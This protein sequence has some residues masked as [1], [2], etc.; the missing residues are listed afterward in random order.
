MKSLQSIQKA[1]HVIRVLTTVAR[2]L[3]VV[4]LCLCVLGILCAGVVQNGGHVFGLLGEP[5]VPFS[6]EADLHT[7]LVRL[8]CTGIVLLAHVILLAFAGS[9]LKA[10]QAD[11]TPFTKRGAQQLNRL[12]IRCIY[13]PIV[14]AALAAGLSVWQGVKLTADLGNAPSLSTGIVLI[15]AAMVFRYGAELERKAHA[16]RD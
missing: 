5:L 6:T 8:A 4:G 15:L 11:G 12:G 9:Y 1:F 3:C 7:T 14:A 2:V 13:I 10:E 16:A